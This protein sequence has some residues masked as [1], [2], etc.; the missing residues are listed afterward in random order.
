M[1][2][3]FT[4]ALLVCTDA[5]TCHWQRIHTPFAS[6][7]ACARAALTRTSINRNVVRYKCVISMESIDE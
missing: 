2:I 5:N 4:L 7:E 3:V 6:E 1:M